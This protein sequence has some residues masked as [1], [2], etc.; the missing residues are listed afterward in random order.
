MQSLIHALITLA[1]TCLNIASLEMNGKMALDMAVSL[2]HAG[3]ENIPRALTIR[4]LNFYIFQPYEL[5]SNSLGEKALV[6]CRDGQITACICY[7]L[8]SDIRTALLIYF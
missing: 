4:N 1:I 8:Q 5:K 2:G 3:R 7:C 6:L